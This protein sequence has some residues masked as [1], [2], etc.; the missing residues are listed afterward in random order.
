MKLFYKLNII[1]YIFI[2][3]CL[4]VFC[5]KTVDRSVLERQK[6]ETL[7]QIEFTQGLLNSTR[8]SKN[9]TVNQLNILNRS[10]SGRESLIKDMEKEIEYLE[11]NIE[12][13]NNK[14]KEIEKDISKLKYE[15]SRIII[16]VYKNIEKEGYL[17]YILGAQ[18]INLCY[19]RI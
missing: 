10:I 7:K 16:A 14:I 19:Q 4:S 2:V 11:Y 12:L 8:K 13:N 3:Q 1:Y 15:Y 9:L 17:E 18:D 6:T 5:Q